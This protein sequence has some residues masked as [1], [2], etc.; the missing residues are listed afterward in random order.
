MRTI[1]QPVFKPEISFAVEAV[2]ERATIVHC[3][4]TEFTA[5]RI[6]P[7]TF[8]IQEDGVRKGLLQAYGITA[9]PNWKWLLPGETFTLVFEGL[10]KHCLLFDLLEEIPEP[11]GFHIA[12]IERN[13]SDVYRL[14]IDE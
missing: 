13:K 8:L 6:W 2:E 10:D 11:G 9:Y 7:S 1:A 4:M 5:A 12:N 3:T 14:F